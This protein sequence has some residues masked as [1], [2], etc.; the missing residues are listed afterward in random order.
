MTEQIVIIWVGV[1]TGFIM[2]DTL[3]REQKYGR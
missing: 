1:M 2:A 3:N